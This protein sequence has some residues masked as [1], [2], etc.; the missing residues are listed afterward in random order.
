MHQIAYRSVRAWI[1]WVDRR[2]QLIQVANR[3]VV[4]VFFTEEQKSE[5]QYGTLL[6]SKS[7]KTIKCD[8]PGYPVLT[9]VNEQLAI[10]QTLCMR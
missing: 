2:S 4:L 6:R 10:A 1:N 3:K 7:V 9:K 5:L 8:V